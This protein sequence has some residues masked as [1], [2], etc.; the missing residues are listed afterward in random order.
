LKAAAPTVPG[1]GARGK[2]TATP[3]VLALDGADGNAKMLDPTV[4]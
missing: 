3:E 2:K 4:R 1:F